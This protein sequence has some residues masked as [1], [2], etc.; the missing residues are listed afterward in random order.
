MRHQNSRLRLKQK[1]AHARMFQRNLVT[2]LLLYESI[3]TTE[4]RAKVIQPLVDRL[5][6]CARNK[7]PQQAIRLINSVVT[8]K[9]ASRKIM[10]V[11]KSRY[12]TRHGGVTKITPVGARLGDGARIV[13]LTLIDAVIGGAMVEEDSEETKKAAKEAKAT[14]KKAKASKKKSATPAA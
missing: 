12:A 5:I 2:S 3:R 8:D 14:K 7:Q 13:D 9:N 1:P 10:E 4:K 11:Y 6:A